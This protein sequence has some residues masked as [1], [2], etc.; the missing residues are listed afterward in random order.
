MT[1]RILAILFA[2]A[3]AVFG[4]AAVLLYVKRADDRAVADMSPVDVLVAKDRV[5][6]GTTG[7]SIRSRE[8]VQVVRL[9]AGS[10]PRDEV[11]TG[12]PSDLDKLVITSDLQPGQIVLRRMFS[13]QTRTAGGLA[14]P[15]GKVAVSFE[16]S[17]AEQV[18]GY[19][20]PGSQV[21][22]FVSYTLSGDGK[23]RALGTGD[24]I[25]GTA[26]LL[27]KVEVIAVGAYGVGVTTTTPID[28]E[29]QEGQGTS[30]LVTV[31]V[32]AEDGAR[33]I[34]AAVANALYLALLNDSSQV[35]P[36]VGVDSRTLFG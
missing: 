9:P 5:P 12:I 31:A 14:I 22:V 26:L 13:Q 3:L 1:R 21:A 7:E 32:S 15:E 36:G 8:L 2:I 29:D 35:K 27:P 16:A 25:R 28:G 6:A 19:V 30:V 24:G 23:T 10:V 18:A 34:Q 20:R 11:L 4:T 33:I 17:M